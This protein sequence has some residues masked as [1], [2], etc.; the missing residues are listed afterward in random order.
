MLFIIKLCRRQII[1][2][3]ADF[4]DI[5]ELQM[6]ADNTLYMLTTSVKDLESSLWNLLLDCLL[7]QEYNEASIIILRCLTHMASRKK[8]ISTCE[9]A[10]VRCI[11]LLAQPLPSFKGN[12]VL[13]FLK[14]IRPCEK[15]AYRS[16]WDQKVTH[17]L[18]YLEQNYDCF[19]EK[20][21]EDLIFDFLSL[22]IESV[23]D[24]V[25]NESLISI[26]R[27]QLLLYTGRR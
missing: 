23:K 18:K 17:L 5:S 4:H 16:V 8:E 21:W 13:N 24:E 12:F 22:L 9:E 27:K 25:F 7:S 14:T 20:E 26:I 6:T 10:F 19:N 3:E 1:G 15:D 11:T 2:K